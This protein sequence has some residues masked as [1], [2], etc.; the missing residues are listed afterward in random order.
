MSW[1]LRLSASLALSLAATTWLVAQGRAPADP[2]WDRR[3][4]GVGNFQTVFEL[5]GRSQL[6]IFRVSPDPQD[7]LS[8]CN[9][10]T[11]TEQQA[12]SGAERALSRVLALPPG[13][14]SPIALAE[15]HNALAQMF[16]Y[17]GEMAKAVEQFER[18]YDVTR[19]YA[20]VDAQL[21]EVSYILELAIAVAS[22]RRGELD[23]CLLD[24]NAERCIFPIRAR[25]VH[26]QQL[27]STQAVEYF[28]RALAQTPDNLEFRW[29]LN[30]AYMT[31][32]RHPDAVPVG[33][34]VPAADA[35]T[36]PAPR[37][38][39]V[40]HES[41]L[42]LRTRAGGAIIDDF[43]NDGRLDVVLSSIGA[44]DPLRLYRN[45]G[46]GRFEDVSERAGLLGQLGGLNVS[47]ADYDNDGWL[48]ILVHRGGWEY[49]Q[50]NSLLRNNGDGTFTDVTERAGLLGRLA[51]RTH[52]AAWA[53][54]DND[55][56][57][58]LYVGHEES[59][60]ALYHNEHD[61]TFREV[62]AAAGVARVAFTKGATWGDYDNDGFADLYVSNYGS[63]NFLFRNRGN[64]TFEEV[65]AKAGVDR[66]L[67][68]FPT[69]FF[70]YDNDGWLDL[71]VAS[72][73]PSVDEVV[74]GMLGLPARAEASKLYRNNRKGGFDDVSSDAG[75]ARVLPAM[76][77]NFGD[78]DNDGFLDVYIGTGAPSYAALVPN[79]MFRN[80]GGR[81]FTDVTAASATGHLQKGH[82][83]AFGDV[84]GDGDEDMLANMGG[85][86]PGDA[87]WKALFRN[88]GNAHHW[89]RIKL[90]G[91]RTNRAGI[92]ARIVAT[93]RQPDGSIAER[94]RVVTSGGSFG[95][96][97]YTQLIGLGPATAIETLEI[98]WPATGA[99]QRFSNVAPDQTIEVREGAD[100]Y[101]QLTRPADS[102]RP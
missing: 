67:M 78:I 5:S 98:R 40:A 6:A 57:V 23:N 42:A 11:Q 62:G 61:G 51:H 36:G 31:L 16:A 4:E 19:A 77:A 58:D 90:T 73:V 59:P 29:L 52:T 37:F 55:G 74:R 12:R 45:T 39:D 27:G 49:P 34:L 72:F 99:R 66:P 47:H 25:G 8:I 41:G 70:D 63:R 24:H 48:D 69:W 53:D 79:F 71:F 14:R 89:L 15:A 81:G 10:Q 102:S 1:P 87:Y 20:A 18:A 13:Q 28:T 35:V 83:V 94:H 46:G 21:R 44:C 91:T 60:A 3:A 9:S 22:L 26:Q 80:D 64:G 96:S 93:V 84:D 86:V 76:G 100:A 75:L 95:A 68:S 38:S 43:D 101:R 32:G 17:D 7:I 50:R 30:V 65:A 92:G 82:G 2:L 33:Y 88:P 97:P 85:F 54:Y 56:W